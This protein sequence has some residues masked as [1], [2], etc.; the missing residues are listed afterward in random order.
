[1]PDAAFS[2]AAASSVFFARLSHFSGDFVWIRE[3]WARL[4]FAP[5]SVRLAAMREACEK[6]SKFGCIRKN[7]AQR[8]PARDLGAKTGLF[9]PTERVA[10]TLPLAKR[11]GALFVASETDPAGFARRFSGGP[12]FSIRAGVPLEGLP[13]L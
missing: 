3:R 7:G 13:C 1:L 8:K 6:A 5:K 2:F 11:F 12:G 4:F 10:A 9:Q